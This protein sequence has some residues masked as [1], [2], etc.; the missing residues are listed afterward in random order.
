MRRSTLCL[1]FVALALAPVAHAQPAV[2]GATTSP[3]SPRNAN[4]SIDARLEPASRT[5]TG[6]EVITWRNIT[7]TR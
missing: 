7:T 2:A 6:S 3:L 5:I 1:S 4:Y